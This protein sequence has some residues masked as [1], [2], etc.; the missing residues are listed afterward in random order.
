MKYLP[1]HSLGMALIAAVLA[2]RVHAEPA[3]GGY[4][5]FGK[6][7]APASGGEFV[8]FNISSNIISMATRLAG[9]SQ[10]EITDL[11]AGLQHIRVNVIGLDDS[12]RAEIRQRVKAVRAELD[13]QGWEKVVTAQEKDQDVVVQLKMRGGEAV[14]GLAVTVI[15][16]DKQAV[17]VNIIGDIKPEKI[18]ALGERFDIEPL[19]KLRIPPKK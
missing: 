8:E 2:L 3:G 10:P 17:M 5:D 9:E 13:G 12:N 4:V 18:A 6:L 14:Q 11:V 16:G 19:K 1:G 15:N 7:S